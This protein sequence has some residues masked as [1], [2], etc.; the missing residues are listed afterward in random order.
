MHDSI[1]RSIIYL[2]NISSFSHFSAAYNF[3]MIVHRRVNY[4]EYLVEIAACLFK[5]IKHSKLTHVGKHAI[6]EFE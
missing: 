6:L 1:F 4:I 2:H 5:T 3:R